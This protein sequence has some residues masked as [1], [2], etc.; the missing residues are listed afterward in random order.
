MWRILNNLNCC[1]VY[2]VYH[3]VLVNCSVAFFG[4][5]DNKFL[6]NIDFA[7]IEKIGLVIYEVI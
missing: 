6:N 1:V 7:N 3:E 2:N 5:L 4:I